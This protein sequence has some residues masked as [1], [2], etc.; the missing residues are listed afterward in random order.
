MKHTSAKHQYQLYSTIGLIKEMTASIA[1][2]CYWIC[3]DLFQVLFSLV[4]MRLSSVMFI[5]VMVAGG[6]EVHIK[7]GVLIPCA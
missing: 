6:G 4:E 2:N 3:L 7:D 5:V 1:T